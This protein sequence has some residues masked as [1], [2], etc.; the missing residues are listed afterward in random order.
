MTQKFTEKE[1][2]R[3]LGWAV[4]VGIFLSLSLLAFLFI[5]FKVNP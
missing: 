1:D 4:E 2:W 3:E 5:Y